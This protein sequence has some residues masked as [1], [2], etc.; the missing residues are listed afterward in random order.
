MLDYIW[1]LL[2]SIITGLIIAKGAVRAAA[3][4]AGMTAKASRESVRET[5]EAREKRDKKR[6]QE[7]IQGVQQA[8]YEELKQI[9]IQLKEPLVK[10]SISDIREKRADY[11]NFFFPVYEDCLVIYR[12]NAN[13]IGQI[14]NP[15]N[16][17]REIV[18][19][20]MGL[21][22]LMELY[23][24]NNRALAQYR[25]VQ[26][27]GQSQLAMELHGRLKGIAPPLQAR[28]DHFIKSAEKLFKILEEKF[29]H[30]NN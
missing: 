19:V 25:E 1:P 29:P 10:N 2:I 13:L 5:L 8:I 21:Q 24:I 26:N 9:D 27:K 12:S 18:G 14:E 11:A 17:R 20:Y 22:V 28:H 3:K 6:Q 4:G 23:R 7:I 30:L 16:L 15:P